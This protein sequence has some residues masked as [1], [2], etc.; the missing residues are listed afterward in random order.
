MDTPVSGT[1]CL[2]LRGEG[3]VLLI[4]AVVG[5]HAIGASWTLFA[6]IVGRVAPAA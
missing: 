5:Y 1:P 2:L 6:V 4:G 3:L